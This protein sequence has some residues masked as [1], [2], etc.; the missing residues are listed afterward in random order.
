MPVFI[1]ILIAA[2]AV[3]AAATTAG[4]AGSNSGDDTHPTDGPRPDVPPPPD[5]EVEKEDGGVQTDGGGDGPGNTR[6]GYNDSFASPVYSNNACRIL[7][8]DVRGDRM[9]LLCG[10]NL[11]R[12]GKLPIDGNDPMAPAQAQFGV[13]DKGAI[14]LTVAG[15]GLVTPVQVV[16]LSNGNFLIPVNEGTGTSMA[17]G[18]ALVAGTWDT[19]SAWT[20]S[21]TVFNEATN[22]IV[23][24][25]NPQIILEP[26]ELQAGLD[27]GGRIW[28]PAAEAQTLNSLLLSYGF[29]QSSSFLNT[30]DVK[31]PIFP[32]GSL[33]KEPSTIASLGGTEV[34]VVNTS[35]AAGAQ[36]VI[37]DTSIPS[38]TNAIVGTIPLNVAYA[39]KLPELALTD[40]KRYA[41][42]AGGDDQNALTKLLVVDLEAR[43]LVGTAVLPPA[44]DGTVDEVRGIAIHDTKAYIS[45]DDKKGTGMSARVAVL[46]FGT[47]DAPAL[48]SGVWVVGNG[49]GAIAAHESG[50][51]YVVVTDRYGEDPGINTTPFSHIVAIDSQTAPLVQIT[52]SMTNGN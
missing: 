52:K 21:T 4:C 19:P 37:V 3:A 28:V 29:E 7:D 10:N 22:R 43:Q 13:G 34:A 11:N 51:V 45:L 30:N 44:N 24:G 2:A 35:G 5:G 18:I 32:G 42:L 26:A 33:Q 15:I 8:L 40:D 17:S 27:V 39:T 36:I 50:T 20:V 9:T 47:P 25:T 1:P 16:E 12:M 6:P 49:G 31:L 41:V 14:G 23:Y 38:S 48:A 46:D